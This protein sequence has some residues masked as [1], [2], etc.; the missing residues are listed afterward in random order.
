MSARIALTIDTE[1]PDHP[2]TPGNLQVILD[3]LGA[4]GAR[5][6]FFIQGR[7]A[8]TNPAIA[9]RIAGDGHTIGNHSKSHAPMDM[10]TDAGIA[11]SLAE[12]EQMIEQASG[13][14]PRPWFRCPYG[15][16]QDDPRVLAAIE[17]AGYRHVGWTIVPCDWEPGR[18]PADLVE[19]VL[20]GHARGGDGGIV[21][22]HSW[23]DVTAAAMPELLERLRGAGADL[24]GVEQLG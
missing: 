20:E 9:R 3:A 1:H 18:T 21:L 16:G 14:N 6:T 10:L 8:N 23:P 2:C 4:A 22:L 19:Q 17:R 15:D 12:A 11:A 5:A 7:W 13:V 24:V